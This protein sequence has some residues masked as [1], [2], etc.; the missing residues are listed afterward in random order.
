MVALQS[1]IQ[2]EPVGSDLGSGMGS[3]AGSWAGSQHVARA[4][5]GYDGGRGGMN[6]SE[7]SSNTDSAMTLAFADDL[8]EEEL[9]RE[10]ALMQYR[11]S[12]G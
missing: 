12:T 9:A 2:S 6:G 8:E 4:G 1:P 5:S 10:E 3:G 11:E 7:V